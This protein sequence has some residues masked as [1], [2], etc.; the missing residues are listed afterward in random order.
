MD[1][2]Y[3]EMDA[4]DA[5]GGA[6]PIGLA[7]AARSGI[8]KLYRDFPGWLLKAADN[9][10]PDALDI[11]RGFMD[12]MCR[13]EP[14]GL[15]PPPTA[16][17]G[18]GECP[19]LYLV[20]VTPTY[21][22]SQGSTNP[23][24]CERVVQP[25]FNSFAFG[26]I[27]GIRLADPGLYTSGACVGVPGY[28]DI[29]LYCSGVQQLGQAG[30]YKISQSQDPF[31][32]AASITSVA[33]QQSIPPTGCVDP[34]PD[35]P[36]VEPPPEER[37]YEIPIEVRPGLSLSF[38]FIFAPMEFEF[39]ADLSFDFNIPVRIGDFNFRFELPGVDAG[40]PPGLELPPGV[41][42]D[43]TDTNDRVRDIQDQVEDI[44]KECPAACDLTPVLQ[45]IATLSS[46]VVDLHEEDLE[47]YRFLAQLLKDTA[48]LVY[49]PVESPG[50]LFTQA[51][52][53]GDLVQVFSIPSG[54][55]AAIAVQLLGTLPP[56][57]RKYTLDSDPENLE[58]GFGSADLCLITADGGVYTQLEVKHLYTR[59][60][61]LLIPPERPP[62]LIARVSL[63]APMAFN[64]WDTGLRWADPI[65]PPSPDE[66]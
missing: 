11:P 51:P 42:D 31:V 17:P 3:S 61:V 49:G 21:S 36:F 60:T 56:S 25:P 1:I 18:G 13:N 24:S 33:P 29:E 27:G 55:I 34:E 39:N 46:T 50:V 54:G 65:F 37:E 64:V 14:P 2:S 63:K 4:P 38:P 48:P 5:P 47:W 66:V 44:P 15:P 53:E 20:T 9:G 6:S 26:P 57:I 16:P 40:N 41:T 32:V 30:W 62:G 23:P 52:V 58:A 59:R 22:R 12:W 19:I 7:N 45:A 10:S 35:Y 8:C 43:I 28:R